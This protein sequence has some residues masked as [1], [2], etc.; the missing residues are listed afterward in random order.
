[1]MSRE[2]C[3]KMFV[4]RKTAT[5][6][7]NRAEFGLVSL[8]QNLIVL[9]GHRTADSLLLKGEAQFTPFPRVCVVYAFVSRKANRRAVRI[10]NL[11]KKSAK[12]APTKASRF[13][14]GLPGSVLA[15]SETLR[16]ASRS[17]RVS[18]YE[19][20]QG[21]PV[22]GQDG[23]FVASLTKAIHYSFLPSSRLESLRTLSQHTRARH[24]HLLGLWL[25]TTAT[26]SSD[27]G[28]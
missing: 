11:K 6:S 5:Y 28:L 13:D 8:I 18:K 10:G 26:T 24:Q 1:M 17:S 19:T 23:E 20:T 4:S 27:S 16:R 14:R 2:W 9:K 7:D 21:Y 3:W 15:A 22:S 12:A 25:T